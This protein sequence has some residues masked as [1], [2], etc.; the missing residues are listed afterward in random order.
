[1]AKSS[2]DRNTIDLFSKTRGRPRTQILSRQEQLKVSKKVQRIKQK[3]QGLKRVE[4]ILSKET[5]EKLDQ[6]CEIEGVKRADWIEST[7][8][9]LFSDSNTQRKIKKR[10][11]QIAETD[12]D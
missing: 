7:I 3:Q 2:S 10:Q 12:S 9:S 5:I 8:E 1:M 11:Q 4:V 6:L